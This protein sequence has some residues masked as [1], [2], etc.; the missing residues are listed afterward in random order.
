KVSGP[1]PVETINP[2]RNQSADEF[3][4]SSFDELMISNPAAVRSQRFEM[5]AVDD[6]HQRILRPQPDRP[7]LPTPDHC[8]RTRQS[9]DIGL[10]D[11]LVAF[12]PRSVRPAPRFLYGAGPARP[13]TEVAHCRK[14]SFRRRFDLRNKICAIHVRHMG[15]LRASEIG[16]R[17]SMS[18]G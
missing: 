18:I 14:R 11:E 17:T 4:Q 8:T 12:A 6:A 1:L 13:G 3:R 15:D 2:L 9:A 10:H 16:F 7:T 5:N